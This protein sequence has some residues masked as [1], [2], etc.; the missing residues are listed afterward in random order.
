MN[1]CSYSSMPLHNVLHQMGT[2]ENMLESWLIR[3]TQHTTKWDPSTIFTSRTWRLMRKI[4][5][6]REIFLSSVKM[7]NQLRLRHVNMMSAP[8]NSYCTCCKHH[9]S[10]RNL[11]QVIID[12]EG[13]VVE[14]A[15][16]FCF[17]EAKRSYVT[18]FYMSKWRQKV[19]PSLAWM[20]HLFQQHANMPSSFVDAT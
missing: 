10:Q 15:T 17:G 2:N 13:V 11:Q 1:M 18:A 6:I 7:L 12:I 20:G 9:C 16:F 14:E 19:L 8:M 5:L 3:W 4:E